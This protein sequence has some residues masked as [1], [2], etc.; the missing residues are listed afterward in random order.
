[1]LEGLGHQQPPTSIITDNA[2]A[3]GIINRTVKQQKSKAMDM[4]YYW[5]E[6][7]ID[8]KHF[9][10]I[11]KLGVLNLGDLYTKYHS[12]KHHTEIQEQYVSTLN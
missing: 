6:A 9:Q 3:K 4:L 11:W 2:V 10:V 12:Q 5:I 1:M 8:Q 7:Q